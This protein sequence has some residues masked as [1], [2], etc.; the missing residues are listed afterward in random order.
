MPRNSIV[1]V[2][3]TPEERDFLHARAKAQ[4]RSLSDFLRIVSGLQPLNPALPPQRLVDQRFRSG[5]GG[6]CVSCGD[7]R[8]VLVDG[9]C[10][11]CRQVFPRR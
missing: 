2:R 8:L 3:M 6:I 10:N 5:L 7:E 1:Q 4:G 9:H 11:K